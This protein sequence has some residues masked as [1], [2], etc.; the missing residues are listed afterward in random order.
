MGWM[1]GVRPFNWE[2]GDVKVEAGKGHRQTL[3]ASQSISANV[4]VCRP[5]LKV[6]VC[7][8][9]VCGYYCIG[10]AILGCKFLHSSWVAPNFSFLFFTN[11][12]SSL[13]L[14]RF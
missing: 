1:R 4:S 5:S 6:S 8:L 13:S 14:C 10:I 2:K 9:V 11:S 3:V 7:Y 12:F